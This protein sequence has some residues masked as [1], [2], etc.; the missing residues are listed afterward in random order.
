MAGQ[1]GLF[2]Q[3]QRQATSNG[4]GYFQCRMLHF[5]PPADPDNLLTNMYS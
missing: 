2:F 3:V 5:H 1:P 4:F